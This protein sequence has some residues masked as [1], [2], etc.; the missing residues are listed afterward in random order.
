MYTKIHAGRARA[1]LA[2]RGTSAHTQKECNKALPIPFH[3]LPPSSLKSV[4]LPFPLAA[5]RDASQGEA[6]KGQSCGHCPGGPK[7][8]KPGC[9]GL[10]GVR[11]QLSP[12]HEPSPQLFSVSPGGHKPTIS[13]P[14]TCHKAG[15]GV[16]GT[17]E[18]CWKADWYNWLGERF[19]RSR[20]STV[21]HMPKTDS[22]HKY[23][24]KCILDCSMQH[25]SLSQW[26]TTQVS[27]KSNK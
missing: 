1:V 4:Q 6:L 15:R 7:G 26:E 18:P 8:Q 23:T 17:L 16:K 27:P 12:P 14:Q 20:I 21:S 9:G 11:P 19:G 24:R 25:L 13:G 5:L 3:T 10:V 22:G 2:A